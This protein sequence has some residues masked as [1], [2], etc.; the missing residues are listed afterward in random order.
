CSVRCP[1]LL[2]TG[3]G[4]LLCRHDSGAGYLLVTV[5]QQA[6]EQASAVLLR[7]TERFVPPAVPL[8]VLKREERSVVRRLSRLLAPF[9]QPESDRHNR[10]WQ[11]RFPP[12]PRW[13]S[14]RARR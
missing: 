1:T 5:D 3:P 11:R 7:V 4:R 10:S 13:Q 9:A 6:T 12:S 8:R 14:S 2:G